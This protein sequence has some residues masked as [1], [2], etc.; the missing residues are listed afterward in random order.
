MDTLMMIAVTGAA[1]ALSFLLALLAAWLLLK[2]LFGWLM[3]AR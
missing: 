1:A 3:A 2:G